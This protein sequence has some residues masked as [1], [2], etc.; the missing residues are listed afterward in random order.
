MKGEGWVGCYRM[1]SAEFSGNWVYLMGIGGGLG[2][3]KRVWIMQQSVLPTP[4]RGV[5]GLGVAATEGGVG[6][7]PRHCLARLGVIGFEVGCWVER[8]CGFWWVEMV[9]PRRGVAR[10][11][12]GVLRG[13]GWASWVDRC[14]GVALARLGVEAWDVT[15]RRWLAE[16]KDVGGKVSVWLGSGEGWLSGA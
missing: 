1:E 11:G 16:W 12:V 4:K 9:T 10:L 2:T 6:N 8:V 5:W 3:L 7:S 13:W 14:L 15:R